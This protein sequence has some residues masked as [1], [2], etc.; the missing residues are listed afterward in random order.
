MIAAELRRKVLRLELRG[1]KAMS[2]ITAGA[3]RSAFRGKGS[4]FEEIREYVPGDDTRSID[5]NVTAR[6]G[7]PHLKR[8][9]EEREQTLMF[10]VD[11]SS[12]TLFGSGSTRKIDAIA[13][14]FAVLSL[15][16]VTT[17]DEVGLILFANNVKLY[18]PPAKGI[19]H[20]QRMIREVLAFEPHG[21][22]T[23]LAGAL[24][25]LTRVRRKRAFVF[26][27]SDFLADTFE[28]ELRTCAA[29]H[30]L[31]AVSVFDARETVLPDCGLMEFEDSESGAHGF[32]D[33]GDPHVRAAFE[34]VATQRRE[35]LES[36]FRSAG[37][38]HLRIQAGSDF[39]PQLAR[40]LRAHAK[41]A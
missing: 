37:I 18:V 19:I 11:A 38:D 27:I 17:H 8:F 28:R 21:G 20:V 14:L 2:L 23:D 41:A 1:R 40:F 9:S 3:Y 22:A 6:L 10:L 12:S 4:E 13:E 26:L 25:F 15:V 39:I 36:V 24:E 7:R 29:R 16:A 32:L 33:T 30:D 5:W 35:R 34:T 31:V